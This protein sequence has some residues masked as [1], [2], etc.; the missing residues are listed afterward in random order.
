MQHIVID[1]SIYIYILVFLLHDILNCGH[2]Y[3][4]VLWKA[5]SGY[6]F[7]FY[8]GK[9]VVSLTICKAN[10]MLLNRIQQ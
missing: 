4:F 2:F 9:V 6:I 5:A 3:K 1:V 8:F 10:S 7:H